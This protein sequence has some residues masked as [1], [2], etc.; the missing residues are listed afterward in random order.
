[1]CCPLVSQPIRQAMGQ[2][3]YRPII[4]RI[5]WYG[6]GGGVDGQAAERHGSPLGERTTEW[7]GVCGQGTGRCVII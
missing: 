3:Y 2:T 7:V 6:W 4:L 5:F 1:M